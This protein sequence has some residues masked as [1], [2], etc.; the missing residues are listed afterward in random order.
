MKLYISFGALDFITGEQ[1]FKS[2]NMI[3]Y[4]RFNS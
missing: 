2:M 4:F 1:T 3:D